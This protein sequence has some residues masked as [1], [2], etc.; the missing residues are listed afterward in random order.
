[1][2][3]VVCA[4]GAQVSAA[5]LKSYATEH[6]APYKKPRA[7]EFVEALPKTTYGKIDKK[8]LRAPHWA[9]RERMV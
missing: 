2:A 5:E 6:L 3:V 8:A 9:G 1:M 4:D 7:F